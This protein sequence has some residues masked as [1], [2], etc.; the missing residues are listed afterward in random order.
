MKNR[1]SEFVQF[2]LFCFAVAVLACCSQA[3]ETNDIAVEKGVSQELATY[4]SQVVSELAYALHF[5]IPAAKEQPIPATE[6][7]SFLLKENKSPLQL[8]FKENTDHLK[9]LVVNQKPVA[10]DHRDE[11]IIIPT[12]S[13]QVGKNRIDIEFVAGNLSLNRSDDFLYT[14]LVPD[15]ARTVF[16]VFEQPSLKATFQLTLTLPKAWQ[17]LANGPLQDSVVTA[18]NKTYRFAPSDTI[19]TYLFSFAAG[20]FQRIS[21]QEK[22]RVMHFLHRETD[23]SKLKLSLD[24]IFQ[25]HSDALAF[26]QSYTGIPY[27]FQKFDFVALPDF[28]Y[29]GMEHVGAIDYKAATLFLDEG[30]TQDQKLAR[31][32]LIAHETAHMW[33]GDL[34]TMQ[35]F[36]DV[37]MKEVFAN[38]MADKITQIAVKNSN[39]DLKFVL[40]HFPAAYGIDRTE[41]ANPIRQPLE[42]LQD[43]GSLYGNIIYHKAPIMMRQLERLMGPEKFQQGLQEYLRKYA[44]GNA[45]WPDLISLLDARTPADLQA[46]NQVWVNEPGRPVF[47]YDLQTLG[48]KITKLTLTQKAEDKSDRIWPQ[49]FEILLVYPT[50]NK[51]VTINMNQRQVTLNTLKGEPVPT[52]ILFNS[53]GLGYGLFPVDKK[54]P[55]NVFALQNPVARAAAY[56]NLYENMLDGRVVTPLELLALNRRGLSEEEEELN[57]KLLTNQLSDIFWKFLSPAKRP[58]LAAALENEIWQAMQQNPTSNAKK[59]LF[60]AYQSVALTPA[61]QARLYDVWAAEKAPDGVKLTEDDYTSLALALAV[62]NHASDGEILRKQ[63]ARIKNEDRKKRM[64]FLLSAL[65]ADVKTRDAFF[66]SLKDE[67]NRSKEAWVVAAL[68]YL[69]HPLR[70]ETSEKYLPESLNLLA[71]IQQTG[72]IFFP[73]SWLQ[74]SFG[75]YQTPTAARTVRAFLTQH[76][77]YNPKLKA[78]ILQASDD[79][80]RAEKLA[81]KRVSEPGA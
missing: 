14:L 28:Q 50:G 8:D 33:F 63:L 42:N 75:S 24:P 29:G 77:D 47:A 16:P 45:T 7:I 38:F 44:F 68:G 19:S 79:L 64:G 35:W 30:A 22:G 74:A 13:L 2:G 51:E 18:T 5:T 43:A 53:T 20:E 23:Q 6:S 62:R 72:D 57:L 52:Y 32:S 12:A 58:E 17:A 15:R 31:S 26:M 10:I 65:S 69:H 11:H 9:R 46:W 78:K 54:M 39:Y 71:E 40:D 25:I 81:G 59:Q 61:A 34:V 76:P 60:K 1:F 49:L 48:G 67:K 66:A 80:F 73:Y 36:N 4:R 55:A 27:P 37:W 21:R 56:V 41:G 70:A 3:T